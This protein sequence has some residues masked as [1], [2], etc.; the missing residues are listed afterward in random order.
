MSVARSLKVG[1]LVGLKGNNHSALL[2]RKFSSVESNLPDGSGGSSSSESSSSSSSSSSSLPSSPVVSPL[3]RRKSLVHRNPRP[4][5]TMDRLPMTA[6]A[7][8]D[9]HSGRSH[10]KSM[11]GSSPLTMPPSAAA[12]SSSQPK[13]SRLPYGSG[14]TLSSSPGPAQ[15]RKNHRRSMS[16]GSLKA[17]EHKYTASLDRYDLSRVPLPDLIQLFLA[18]STDS[19]SPTFLETF[20][21]SHSCFIPSEVVLDHIIE[22]HRNPPPTVDP[23]LVS[24]W[25]A[26]IFEKWIGLGLIRAMQWMKHE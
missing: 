9:D 24:A 2:P 13:V 25:I 22:H 4:S 18:P 15:T 12:T 3:S 23:E 26:T 6:P 19:G 8:T 1:I 21:V 5:S 17:S 11:A 20:L 7:P 10:A 16:L 14:G